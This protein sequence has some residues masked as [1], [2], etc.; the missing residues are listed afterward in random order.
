MKRRNSLACFGRG[1]ALA[2]SKP[3]LAVSLW[4]IQLL[5]TAVLILPISNALHDL[6]DHSVAGSR[7]VANPDYGLWETLQRE[8]PDLLGNLPDLTAGLLT[9]EGVRFSQLA[10]LRGIGAAAV[11]LGFLAVVLHAFALGG[12]FGTLREPKASLV[13]FGREGMRRFPA[14]LIFTLA[15]VAAVGAAY[16]W[17]YVETGEAL[18]DRVQALD[19]EGR[20]LAVTGVRLAALLFALAAI[21][22]L[23][24]SVRVTWVARPDLPPISRFFAG[25]AAAL[26][27]PI[28][29]FGV[30]LW[31]TIVTAFL[32]LAW[33]L[34]DP[35]AGGEARFALVPLILTQQ[36]FVFVR[37]LIKVGYYAGISEA[38]TRVP[39]PEYSYVAPPPT[40]ESAPPPEPRADDEGPIQNPA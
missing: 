40:P 35:S 17:I 24:D 36:V 23:A 1:L 8:H 3:Y 26:G 22:L 7:M 6:L 30:L 38:L 14:F 34:A 28:R 4:L 27:R 33:L 18:R 2:L 25:I 10:D 20:A 37:L 32:Y 11:S 31:Y 15:T 39:S 13:T 16:R 29:L 9:T 5:L 21:K 19:T 12:V